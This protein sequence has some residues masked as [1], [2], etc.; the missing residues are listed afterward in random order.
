MTPVKPAAY[1]D[2]LF[3]N[4]IE[5][6]VHYKKSYYYVHWT[7]VV[8][9]LRKINSPRVREIGCGTGQLAEYL[10]DENLADGYSGFDFSTSA[11]E[12]A[13]TR[14]S[15]RF[16]QGDALD[17][18]MY[19]GNY[20]TVI[21]LEV[22][23][24]IQDDLLVLSFIPEGTNIIFSVPNFDDPSH[25]RWF[26][27]ERQ[28]KRRF[29]RFVDIKEIVRIGNIYVCRGI[30]SQFRPTPLQAFLASRENVNLASFTKRVK[31]R[32][33]NHLKLKDQ[34]T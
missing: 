17:R 12:R 6:H 20:N 33:K 13:R 23:E 1:Y 8:V 21:C 11:V 27:S 30:V 19:K 7:Q 28:I 31:H 34:S 2:Q 16:I 25:V 29:F 22:L 4:K 32:L 15:L 26:T 24:H 5:F 3:D 9:F 18:E 14:T 10:R